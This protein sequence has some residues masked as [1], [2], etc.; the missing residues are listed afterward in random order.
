MQVSAQTYEEIYNA[1]YEAGYHHLIMDDGS[2]YL[3]NIAIEPTLDSAPS[4]STRDRIMS[5]LLP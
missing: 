2:I 1:L 5:K 3:T 4:T